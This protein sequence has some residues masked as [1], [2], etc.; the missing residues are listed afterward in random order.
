MGYLVLARKWR[1]KS[2]DDLTG[3]PH[4]VKIL[5]NTI[6]KNKIHHAYIFSG[7]RGV[8]KTTTARI[9]AR[10]LNCI[11]GPTHLPCNKCNFCI[12]ITEGSSM[13]VIEI[14]G[15]SNNSVNDIRDI[16]ERVRYAPSEGK[17]KVYIID[18]AHMLSEAAFNAF[19]KTLEEPP[20]STIF[21]LATTAYRKIPVTVMSRCQHLSFRK[22]PRE[23]IKKRLEFI[24]RE[25]GIM[26]DDGAL[27]II[28]KAADGSMRDA[29]TILDQVSSLGNEIKKE[30]IKDMLGLSDSQTIYSLIDAIFKSDK[31]RIIELI[32]EFSELGMDL[33]AIYRDL[34][35]YLRDMVILKIMEAS[36]SQEEL[37][38]IFDLTMDD[39]DEM[40]SLLKDVSVEEIT[41]IFNELLKS[42]NDI[43]DSLFPR[44]V[45]EMSLIRASLLRELTPVKEAIERLRNI[46]VSVNNQE[47]QRITEIQ[48]KKEVKDIIKEDAINSEK[49][50][51]K[52]EFW[53]EILRIID[54]KYHILASKIS[55]AQVDIKDNSITLKFNGGSSIHARAVKEQKNL[56]EDIAKKVFMKTMR[57]NIE[58]V[59][60]NERV[61]INDIK[62]DILARPEVKKVIDIFE[63]S[64]VDIKKVKK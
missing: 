20:P 57:L 48:K 43:K 17:Y 23:L 64:I 41:I 19:L 33:K 49:Q 62:N 9:L 55:L 45:F 14:D 53:N 3:Q 29:L 28:S 7:P 63:G 44:I 58:S 56:I 2:L 46:T 13:D 4:I 12:S 54:K 51:N 40:R 26:I 27:D 59:D 61:S 37:K 16:R 39:I 60:T 24:S 21:V 22:I 11:N 31:K 50:V 18:E 25:E 35:M 6:L 1:P 52:D 38:N 30:D 34:L 5:K 36:P 47:M 32:N 8:G 10:S 42:E 15:A